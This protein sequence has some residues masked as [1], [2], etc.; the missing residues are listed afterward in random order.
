MKTTTQFPTPP[1][2]M[3]IAAERLKLEEAAWNSHDPEQIAEGYAESIEM[4]DGLLFIS[5]R[6]ALKQFIREKFSTQL[7]YTL[8]L[9]LWGALK[10]RMAVCFEAEWYDASGQ[11]FR[12]YGV[13]VFQFNETG[14]VERRFASQETLPVTAA[15]GQLNK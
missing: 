1:W 6:E 15:D 12:S 9:E 3:D 4:R 13:Q 2:D 8:K 10:G 11:W 7:G 5:G 14:H